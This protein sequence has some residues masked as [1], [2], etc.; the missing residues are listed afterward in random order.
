MLHAIRRGYAVQLFFFGNIMMNT[1]FNSD[2]LTVLKNGGWF[3]GRNIDQSQIEQKIKNNGYYA[4]KAVLDFLSEFE[5]LSFK[6]LNRKNNRPDDFNFKLD[7]VLEIEVPEKLV[8]D[9][10]PRT[11]EKLCVIGTCCREHFVLM[12]SDTGKM[13]GAYDDY[14]VLFGESTASAL[15]AIVCGHELVKIP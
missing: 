13:Y 10:M 7:R 3:P 8:E 11:N 4:F 1:E 9:Y 2:T 15:N 12:L 5:G 14:L 6:F